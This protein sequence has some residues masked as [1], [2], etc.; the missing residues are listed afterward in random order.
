MEA[1]GLNT[2]VSSRV[3]HCTDVALCLNIQK[4][5]HKQNG[6][7]NTKAHLADEHQLGA[8]AGTSHTD[9]NGI[10][11]CSVVQVTSCL[12]KAFAIHLGLSNGS[13]VSYFQDDEPGCCSRSLSAVMCIVLW[14]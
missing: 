7:C 1:V 8:Q 6:M 5:V 2:E 3:Q 4:H 11:A 10:S 9:G 14:V 12:E 13:R